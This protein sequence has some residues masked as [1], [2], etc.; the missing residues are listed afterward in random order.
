MDYK[1]LS[2]EQRQE[3][4]DLYLRKLQIRFENKIEYGKYYLSYSGGKDSHLLYWFIK[5]YMKIEKIKI[6]GVN[7]RME[8]DEIR[9]RLYQY[10]DRVLIPKRT[11]TDVKRDFGSP[12]FTKPQDEFVKR[13]QRGCR[14]EYMLGKFDNNS[15]SKFI[16]S[17]K[18]QKDR[19]SVV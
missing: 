7:T 18:A 1:K 15:R 14:T 16:L 11:M 3:I 12:C 2:L 9:D 4:A 13:W 6:I 17:K 8:H 5:H 10:C 19:K